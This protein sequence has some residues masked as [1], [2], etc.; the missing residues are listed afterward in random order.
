MEGFIQVPNIDASYP[1]EKKVSA[2]R[3]ITIGFIKIFLPDR[4]MPKRV[5][6]TITKVNKIGIDDFCFNLVSYKQDVASFLMNFSSVKPNSTIQ[7]KLDTIAEEYG[8]TLFERQVAD[9]NYFLE[10]IFEEK[11][12]KWI[13]SVYI[14]AQDDLG[15]TFPFILFFILSQECYQKYNTTIS[16]TKKLVQRLSNWIYHH[17][18]LNK[19]NLSKFSSQLREILEKGTEP[20]YLEMKEILKMP[21]LEREIILVVLKEHRNGG[22]S[23]EHLTEYLHESQKKISEVVSELAHKG[24]LRQLKEKDVTI[25]DSLW[26]I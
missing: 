21:T 5:N 15:S 11:D 10:P 14:P 3:H 7:F 19:E 17:D 26:I 8:K 18:D 23:L 4:T 12:G 2:T 16:K 22:I 25:I 24:F 13:T 1:F 9:G 20:D 6:I